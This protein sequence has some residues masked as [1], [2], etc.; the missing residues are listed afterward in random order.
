MPPDRRTYL[1][2]AL[3]C[4][5]LLRFATVLLVARPDRVAG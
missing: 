3:S 2:D 4:A 1:W 5:D